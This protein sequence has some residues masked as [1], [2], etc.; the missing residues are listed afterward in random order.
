MIGFQL[1]L[2]NGPLGRPKGWSFGMLDANHCFPSHHAI[3]PARL[4][5]A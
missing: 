5:S 3:V 2:D 1:F 4:P